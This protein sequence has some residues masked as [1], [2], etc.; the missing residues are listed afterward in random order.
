M[1]GYWAANVQ[2]ATALILRP[3]KLLAAT[4][5][6]GQVYGLVYGLR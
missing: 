6:R 5:Q 3:I 1:A 2:V 4:A